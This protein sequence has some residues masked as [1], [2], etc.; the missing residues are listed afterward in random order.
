MFHR[1]AGGVVV[2]A[3]RAGARR[4]GAVDVA[5][6]GT[7][8]GGMVV[9]VLAGAITAGAVEDDEV[10]DDAGEVDEGDVG[11]VIPRSSKGLG[12]AT[13]TSSELESTVFRNE[14]WRVATHAPAA[15]G[16]SA[17]S[18]TASTRTRPMRLVLRWAKLAGHAAT[19]A[20]AAEA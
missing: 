18:V 7:L 19:A 20:S 3:G 8:A 2:G 9:V 17:A 6:A 12:C 4:A 11:A 14:F 1:P 15:P 10:E 5:V 16:R 13:W